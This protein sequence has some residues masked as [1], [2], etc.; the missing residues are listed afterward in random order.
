MVARPRDTF[1]RQ[2]PRFSRA[3][4]A[5]SELNRR[6]NRRDVRSWRHDRILW[7]EVDRAAAAGPGGSGLR[8]NDAG[9]GGKP[10]G[11]PGWARCGGAGAYW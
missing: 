7:I 4:L 1:R 8:R 9:T 2:F 5:G 3:A 10:P 6:K 11:H